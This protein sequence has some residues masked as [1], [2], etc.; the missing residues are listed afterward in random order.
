MSTVD[1]K[2]SKNLFRWNLVMGFLHLIQAGVMFWL[3]KKQEF[4]FTITLPKIQFLEPIVAGVQQRPVI[5]FV[6]EK[7][8]S[9]N[10]G[11]MIGGFL[12][13]SAIAHFVTILPSVFPWYIKKLGEKMNLIRW[14][15]YAL[16]SS[17][18]I[19]VI[20]ALCNIKDASI[21]VL[22]FAINACMNLFGAM[23]EKH[24][25]A[26]RAHAAQYEELSMKVS[27]KGLEV[28]DK[29]VSSYKTDWTAFIYGTFAGLVPWLVMGVYFFISIGRFRDVN[30]IPQQVKDILSLV[31]WIFPILFVFFNLFAINMFLQYR[32]VGKWKDY[33]WGEKMYIL[34]SLLAKSFL[35]WFIWGGTLRP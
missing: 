22:L 5:D 20:A 4:E 16:S 24:N 13:L 8:F 9:L 6:A 30:D 17:I 11:Y 34:L 7:A 25:S 28:E 18:M 33:V 21:I 2:T 14:W 31:Q 19:V 3:S 15:E 12:L 10:L 1:V 26:L 29:L 35:A 23:M 32:M 27:K